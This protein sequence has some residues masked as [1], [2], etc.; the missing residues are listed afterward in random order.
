MKE[1]N[2]SNLKKTSPASSACSMPKPNT[3]SEQVQQK[4]K[5]NVN[6]AVV[7]SKGNNEVAKQPAVR[8]MQ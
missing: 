4:F 3:E 2:T 6:R 1:V 8:L 5:Q 7:D